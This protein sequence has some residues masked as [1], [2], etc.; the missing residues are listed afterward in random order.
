L[1]VTLQQIGEAIKAGSVRDET[2]KA[3]IPTIEGCKD[4]IQLLDTLLA[5]ILTLPIAT[6]SELRTGTK[7]V[8]SFNQEA[9][10]ESITKLLRGYVGSLTFY[11]AAISS[12]LQPLTG[13]TLLK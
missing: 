8:L 2:E 3:L 13:N 9:K 1:K 7:A 12:T 4:K 10:V 11:Y 6:D 5:K